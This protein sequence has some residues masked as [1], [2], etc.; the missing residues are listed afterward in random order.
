MW[1]CRNPQSLLIQLPAEQVQEGKN[2]EQHDKRD[3]MDES[4]DN[5][6]QKCGEDGELMR[7]ESC[8][9]RFHT[10]CC[11]VA[12]VC[13]KPPKGMW[14]CPNC[15]TAAIGKED[16]TE[17]NEG[18][19]EM[20]LEED[21]NMEDQSQDKNEQEAMEKG[22]EKEEK[23]TTKEKGERETEVTTQKKD[24]PGRVTAPR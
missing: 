14:Y 16:E 6:C 5:V 10:N 24:R 23:T 11:Q 22:E 15:V 18:K 8:L 17:M 12:E 3:Q 4:S 19:K 21:H 1:N 2:S 13:S 20:E 9:A 7:C